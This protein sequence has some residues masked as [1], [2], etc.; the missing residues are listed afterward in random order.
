MCKSHDCSDTYNKITIGQM[1]LDNRSFYMY[2]KGVFGW[3]IIEGKCKR[4]YFYDATKKEILLIATADSKEYTFILNF[5]DETLFKEIKNMIFLNKDYLVVVAGDWKSSGCF[6][7]F[8]T[9]FS[10]K[11]Q[12]AIIK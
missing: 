4:P 7:V 10:S 5:D 1:L 11:K 9:A 8:C 2:P 12:L 3:R 6:N